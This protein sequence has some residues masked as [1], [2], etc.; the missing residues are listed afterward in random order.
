VIIVPRDQLLERARAYAL[1]I[2]S[3]SPTAV[4]IGKEILN[5]IEDMD[6]KK[7]YAFEQGF[8]VRLSG[9]ADSKEALRAIAE[10]RSPKYLSRPRIF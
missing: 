8:T 3:F 7:G 9:H 4:R 10:R 2:V 1:R 6:L 5:C